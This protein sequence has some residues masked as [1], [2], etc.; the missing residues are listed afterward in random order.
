MT[1]ASSRIILAL[2]LTAAL[3]SRAY[4]QPDG[5]DAGMPPAGASLERSDFNFSFEGFDPSRKTWV[6]IN[7]TQL[8]YYF[9]RARCECAGDSINFAGSVK[10]VIEP[11]PSAF[12][13]IQSLLAANMAG[14]GE[15]RLYAGSSAYNCLSPGAAYSL[16]SFCLNLVDPSS[17]TAGFPLA[18]FLA[19]GRW[20][21]PPIPVAWLF[22][23]GGFPVCHDTQTC[24]SP[25][26]CASAAIL[27]TLY[28]WVRTSSGSVPDRDDLTVNVSLVGRI[29]A[30]PTEVTVQ[31]QNEALVVHWAWPAGLTPG[32]DSSFL[33][34]QLFCQRGQGNQVFA[35]QTFN[36][37]FMTSATIC[38][39][40]APASSPDLAFDG[41]STS[42]L[43]SGILPVTATSY[44]INGLQNGIPYGVGVAAVDRYGNL[45][46][47]SASDVVYGVPGPSID[48]GADGGV[49]LGGGC[50]LAGSHAARGA[51]LVALV[52]LV[53]GSRLLVRARRRGR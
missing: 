44:R 29:P 43:C 42:D 14:V 31:G 16:A 45:T 2:S 33:G 27:S 53:L 19:T 1:S 8:Q 48:G 26:N 41:L 23:A 36:A 5:G 7:P 4:A 3:S 22:N 20:E 50:A 24:N 9:N 51:Y 25:S 47:L 11:A 6:Q 13:K 35:S 12:A 10:I 21:S 49:Q 18:V 40:V 28:F 52:A 30:A 17:Y 32:A 15:A 46:P 39:E 38:P 34:V 37:A